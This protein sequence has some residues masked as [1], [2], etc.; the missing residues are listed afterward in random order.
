MPLYKQQCN[1]SKCNNE[2]EDF[3]PMKECEVEPKCPKCGSDSS[4]VFGGAF[5]RPETNP[6]RGD[7]LTLEH[8]NVE[9]EGPLTFKSKRE[10]SRYCNKH[11]LESGALL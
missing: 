8:I 1:N 7:G 3:R 10:L 5:R 6:F 4:K 9:G 2:F 11:G